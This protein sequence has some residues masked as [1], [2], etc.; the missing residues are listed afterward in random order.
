MNKKRNI[1]LNKD[2]ALE[3]IEQELK[4]AIQFLD[5]VNQ[6]ILETLKVSQKEEIE[7]EKK[8]VENI[9]INGINPEINS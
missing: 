9:D 3:S 1:K 8:P 7:P 5:S 2:E 6:K 4:S